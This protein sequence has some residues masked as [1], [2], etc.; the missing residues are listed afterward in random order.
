MS[1]WFSCCNDNSLTDAVAL[2]KPLQCN[3]I[4]VN[5]VAIFTSKH[6]LK[7]LTVQKVGLLFTLVC[8]FGSVFWFLFPE[9]IDN[10][11]N[12]SRKINQDPE[13]NKGL[14]NVSSKK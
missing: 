12:A 9:R 6:L 4:A 11:K 8:L 3:C 7:L 10:G 14:K 2:Q 1:Q 13:S 5:Q